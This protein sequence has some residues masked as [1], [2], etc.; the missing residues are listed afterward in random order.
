MAAFQLVVPLA[1][2]ESPV[3]FD[4]FTDVTATLSPAVPL[5]T[6][7]DADVE[8]MVEPGDRIVSEG[9]VVSAPPGDG[10]G[11]GVVGGVGAGVGVGVGIGSGV[12]AG[13][14]DPGLP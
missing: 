4:H 11:V 7:L 8:R 5:N 3:E 14:G 12:G 2:P 1:V 13:T 6:T 10:F 9:G